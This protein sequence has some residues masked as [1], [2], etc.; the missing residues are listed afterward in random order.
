MRNY[1]RAMQSVHLTSEQ[2]RAL[3]Q[4]LESHQRFL[5]R[6]IHRLRE[7]EVCEDDPVLRAA[8]L[9]ANAMDDLQRQVM[10]AGLRHGAAKDMD[11]YKPAAVRR[12]TAI[13]SLSGGSGGWRE[14]L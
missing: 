1:R 13:Q 5:G 3:R 7:L 4:R 8:N 10:R 6:L 9:A 12:A 2:A 11:G 14:L